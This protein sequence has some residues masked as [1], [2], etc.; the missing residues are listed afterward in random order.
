MGCQVNLADS[1][2]AAVGTAAHVPFDLLLC[3]LGLPDG[4]GLELMRQLRS[5][6]V[7][8]FKA[9]AISGFGMEEDLRATREA[10]FNDHLVKPVNLVELKAA[11]QRITQN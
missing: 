5:R 2:S 8:P 9:I 10:G 7:K 4:S 11:M 1:I 3:D 6:A